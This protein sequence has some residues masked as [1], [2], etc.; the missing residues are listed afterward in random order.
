M[1]ALDGLEDVLT[2]F[3]ELSIGHPVTTLVSR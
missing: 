1:H 3:G 2:F